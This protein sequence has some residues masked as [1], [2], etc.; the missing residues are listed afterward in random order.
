MGDWLW[1]TPLIDTC[2]D[3]SLFSRCSQV[4]RTGHVLEGRW[5]LLRKDGP[6]SYKAT[7]S[8]MFQATVED[9]Y[10]GGGQTLNPKP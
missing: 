7:P 6:I 8:G 3:M 2:F 4:T 5:P 10:G 9:G 1:E